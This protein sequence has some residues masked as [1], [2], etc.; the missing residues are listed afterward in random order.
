MAALGYALD[1]NKLTQ[2]LNSLQEKCNN[3]E[4]VSY[5][6]D[7]V[8]VCVY[9]CRVVRGHVCLC[10][11]VSIEG[12]APSC[13]LAFGS[14]S[15]WTGPYVDACACAWGDGAIVRATS[16]AV[17]LDLSP[18]IYGRQGKVQAFDDS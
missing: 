9:T 8:C 4:E 13:V 17:T 7:Q 14:I 1:P 6:P 10:A 11:S 3:I 2:V 16:D 15:R 5:N 18:E 12:S